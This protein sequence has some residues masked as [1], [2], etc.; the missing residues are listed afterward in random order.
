MSTAITAVRIPETSISTSELET[1]IRQVLTAG[2]H[3]ARNR[4]ITDRVLTVQYTRLFAEGAT[5]LAG[6]DQE[7]AERDFSEESTSSTRLAAVTASAFHRT[8]QG[9]RYVVFNSMTGSAA[10]DIILS[11]ESVA[12]IED[13]SYYNATDDQ[14]QQMTEAEWRSRRD[15]WDQVT[16]LYGH[17]PDHMI[18]VKAS[19]DPAEPAV[20]DGAGSDHRD[21]L[22]SALTQTW[23][24][25]APTD[26]EGRV[27]VHGMLGALVDTRRALSRQIDA[28]VLIGLPRIDLGG[29]PVTMSQTDRDA[30]SAVVAQ[31]WEAAVAEG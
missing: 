29:L 5:G 31:V 9:H 20:L 15:T 16:G 26:A 23:P 13:F 24:L 8:Y 28:G 14:L 18:Q 3:R 12:G 2:L 11:D 19:I 25:P 21:A 6:A 27:D 4:E 1:R 17:L 10:H 7:E 22:L 30:V